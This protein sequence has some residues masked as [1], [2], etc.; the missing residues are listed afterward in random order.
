ML[1][2]KMC[3]DKIILKC[4]KTKKIKIILNDYSLD[5]ERSV[6]SWQSRNLRMNIDILAHI[7]FFRTPSVKQQ[8][9]EQQ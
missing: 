2:T 6:C 7:C 9:P 3:P 8:Q 4:T 1:F 5:R